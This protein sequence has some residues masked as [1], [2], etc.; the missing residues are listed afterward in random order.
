[1]SIM[2]IPALNRATPYAT[3]FNGQNSSTTSSQRHKAAPLT[4]IIVAMRHASTSRRSKSPLMR[5]GGHVWLVP[6]LSMQ[7]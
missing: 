3:R 1:M 7:A 6:P 2:L 4:C 5:M